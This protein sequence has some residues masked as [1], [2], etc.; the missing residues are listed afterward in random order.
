M[1]K[2]EV[3]R[4]KILESGLNSFFFTR[5][6]D[7][8]YMT[9][10]NSSNA[11]VI[12]TDKENIFITDGRYYE[13]A[14]EKLKDWKVILLGKDNKNILEDLTEILLEKGGKSIGFQEDSVTLS[15]YKKLTEKTDL[16]ER[17]IG[18]TNFIDEIRMI[19]TEDEIQIIKEAVKKTDIVFK[20]L[21]SEINKFKTEL[22]VRRRIIDLIFEMGGTGESFPAIV[23]SGKHSA[24]PHY[25]TGNFPI[26]KNSPLLIDMGMKFK[27]Y[28]SDFTRT[29]FLGDVD[30]EIRKIYEIVK[31]AH[32]EA[33]NTVKEGVKISE[34]DR[35][36]RKIIEKY[37]YGD[38]FIHSTG[39]GVGIDIHE[40]PRISKNNDDV[41]KENTVFTIEPGIYIPGKGGVRLE[42]IVVC[43]KNQPEVLTE[44][45]LDLLTF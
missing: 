3:I 6:S 28:C 7:I 8:F 33:V 12:L 45:S 5:R 2:I 31:E 37:G 29:I 16:K 9:Y 42:N 14:K 25:E 11:Y 18:F 40:I 23:A 36:A 4:K 17:L 15:F 32:I 27:G 13:S 34:I 24:V 41:L 35:T 43:R 20:K 26:E 30:H 44:T 1:P 22:D 19:K 10:F 21:T 38:Y 39:H